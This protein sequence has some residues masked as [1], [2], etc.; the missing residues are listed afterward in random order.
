MRACDASHYRCAPLRRRCVPMS[1][2]KALGPSPRKRYSSITSLALLLAYRTT[3]AQHR[4]GL[5]SVGGCERR[6][7]AHLGGRCRVP[8]APRRSAGGPPRSRCW[9]ACA[10]RAPSSPPRC[11]GRP[12]VRGGRCAAA[13]APQRSRHRRVAARARR[14]RRAMDAGRGH[15]GAAAVAD[16]L[17]PAGA[18]ARGRG[19]GRAGLAAAAVGAACVLPAS[20]AAS[21]GPFAGN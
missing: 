10:T 11:T 21:L 15:H 3:H 20:P 18:W 17:R 16:D 14:D 1:A 12:Q 9:A 8:L 19:S 13:G 2:Q 6:C 7:R 5:S 4:V